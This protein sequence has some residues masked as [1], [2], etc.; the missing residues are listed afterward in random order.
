MTTRRPSIDITE[1]IAGGL[2]TAFSAIR[3]AAGKAAS[4]FPR[5]AVLVAAAGLLAAALVPVAA[6]AAA[7][8]PATPPVPVLTWRSCDSGFQCAT[9]RVPLNY[10]VPR[11]A[12]ISIA[13]IRH[14]ETDPA[15]RL[16]S[17]FFNGGGPN[18]QIESFVADFGEF[19][20]AVVARYNIITFDPR[21]FGYSTAIRFPTMAAENKF[22]AALPPFP[23]GAR[24]DAAWERTWARFDARCAERGGSLLDHDT[25]ADV[26]R[27]MNLLRQAV[28]APVLNYIGLSYG[29]GLGATYANLFP[30][31]TGHMILD[32]NLNPVAWTHPD[33]VAPI[34]LRQHS[35]QAS[36]WRSWI[37][38][39]RRQPPCA[40]SPRAPRPRLA[41]SGTRCCAA[42]AVTRSP[43]TPRRRPIPTPTRWPPCRW[44]R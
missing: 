22:L 9:A 6:S 18:E 36:G 3:T 8:G 28:G 24:Q 11:G 17:L 1:R 21:G 10:R 25:T 19:P 35:D 26:A 13:V 32:G 4:R 7:P 43:S 2:P 5:P 12:T 38:A 44:A 14:Q 29:T 23:V 37:S 27:D 15:H 42:S 40:R 39:A 16:G 20:A 34:W 31:T 33:A 41:P 30:A